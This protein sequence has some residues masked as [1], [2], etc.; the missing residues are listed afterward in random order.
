[1]SA[2]YVLTSVITWCLITEGF[3]ILSS[4]LSLLTCILL[5]VQF[6]PLLLLITEYYSWAHGFFIY[7]IYFDSLQSLLILNL[8]LRSSIHQ[9]PG[10]GRSPGE[11][12]GQLQYSGLESM[13]SQRVRHNRATFTFTFIQTVKCTVYSLMPF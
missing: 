6:G 9:I 5:Y 1:M 11:A 12:K 3:L 7:L 4:L 10:L 2:N 13:E 8:F